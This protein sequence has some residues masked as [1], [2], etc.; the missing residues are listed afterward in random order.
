MKQFKDSVLTP[1]EYT[2]LKN[3]QKAKKRGKKI[4]K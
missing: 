3:K 2:H 4:R 1:K